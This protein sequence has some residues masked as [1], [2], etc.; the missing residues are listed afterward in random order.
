MKSPCYPSDLKTAIRSLEE[1]YAQA[2]PRGKPNL[3][4]LLLPRPCRPKQEGRAISGPAFSRRDLSALPVPFFLFHNPYR[5]APLIKLQRLQLSI[6]TLAGRIHTGEMSGIVDTA[7]AI[8]PGDARI[9]T[10]GTGPDDLSI[11][12]TRSSTGFWLNPL[13][14]P[15]DQ[16]I[17]D[18]I[19][20]GA[21]DSSAAVEEAGNHIELVEFLCCSIPY[22]VNHRLIVFN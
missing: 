18:R 2:R 4:K 3:A 13:F 14:N 19:V 21:T 5:I 8:V 20:V 15:V 1:R 6:R 11:N 17:K 9:G 22:I 16:R 10:H 12:D 7:L